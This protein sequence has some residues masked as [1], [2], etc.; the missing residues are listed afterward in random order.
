[1]RFEY[2]IGVRYLR[3]RRRQRFVSLI[4]VISLVGVTIGT[5]ALTVVLSVMSGFQEDLR[6]R[7]LSF[8]P[9]ITVERTTVGGGDLTALQ[10]RIA[11]LP[12]V[13]GVAP[14]IS[15]QVMM[16]SATGTGA[17][18]FVGGGT[19]RGVVARDN[20]VLT[21]LNRTLT[22]G[23]LAA[24]EQTYPVVITEHGKQRTVRLPGAIIGKSLAADLGLRLGDPVVVI[25]PASL[26]AGAGAPRLR[27][28]VV[29]GFFYSGMY[30]FDAALIFVALRDGQALLADDPQLERGLEVRVR[31]PFDAPAIGHEIAGITGS[32][33][34]V[35]DWTENNAALFSALKLE[36]LTYFLVL[37]L[38]VLVAAFNIVATLVMV[39]MERRKEI[40]ILR[41]MGARARSIA[42]IFLCEGAA[43]G[44]VGTTLG[45]LGGFVTSW[46]IGKYHLIHLP[47]DLFMV[48]AVP[49][50]LYAVNFIA[51]AIAAVI[52]CA[53]GAIYPAL[54]ARSL[55]PVEVIRYE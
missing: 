41:A 11:T 18:G 33:F 25:S 13:V 15:S 42:A 52:L 1:M 8:N 7:L 46:L 16:V 2:L 21:E 30:E 55:S 35:K 9:H 53:V 48:S 50:R 31:S 51:V 27:R 24:L 40:A 43:L 45:V 6:D 47:P 23:S 28:F 44:A 22:A 12:D 38:I 10:A 4:A 32:A 3:A 54:Q 37:L 26:G 5:F 17:P 39:V 36:K 34:T 19:L 14:F 49:V 20:P 29:S